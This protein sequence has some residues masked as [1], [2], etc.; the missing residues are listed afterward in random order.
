MLFLIVTGNKRVPQEETKA[1]SR[2][3]VSR[4]P[5]SIS[6][7]ISIEVKGGVSKEVKTID[8]ET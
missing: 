5:S 6:I 1:S 4:I 3:A 7:R 8:H 2:V